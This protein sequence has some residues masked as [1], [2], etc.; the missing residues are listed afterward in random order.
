MEA[1]QQI[2]F[3]EH[4]AWCVGPIAL[5]A[6]TKTEINIVTIHDPLW[7]QNNLREDGGM[8]LNDM[9]L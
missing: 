2:P 9:F 5:L 6:V 1:N 3:L 8:P 4:G 7:Y